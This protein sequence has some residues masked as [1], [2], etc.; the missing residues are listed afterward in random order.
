LIFN[1]INHSAF[2]F[3]KQFESICS[4]TKSA[5]SFWFNQIAEANYYFGKRSN[6]CIHY[7]RLNRIREMHILSVIFIKITEDRGKERIL[8]ARFIVSTIFAVTESF[9]FWKVFH[10]EKCLIFLTIIAWWNNDS[11]KLHF[12]NYYCFNVSNNNYIFYNC[13]Y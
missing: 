11:Y 4:A 6:N 12:Y 5:F 13:Q 10:R 8:H 1:R 9:C 7:I 2:L 3:R